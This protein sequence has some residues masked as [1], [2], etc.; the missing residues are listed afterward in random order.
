MEI[1]KSRSTAQVCHD[2]GDREGPHMIGWSELRSRACC[3]KT[4]GRRVDARVPACVV[5]WCAA[6]R[7]GG[8]KVKVHVVDL[9]FRT[10]TVRRNLAGPDASLTALKQT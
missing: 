6:V 3:R 8:R 10:K 7:A 2:F 5:E 1:L 9:T 4:Q